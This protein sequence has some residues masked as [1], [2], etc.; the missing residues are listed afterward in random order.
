M[1]N[2]YVYGFTGQVR[3]SRIIGSARTTATFNTRGFL[4]L[5]SHGITK[6]N[7]EWNKKQRLYGFYGSA[8]NMVE[9]HS[10]VVSLELVKLLN[11]MSDCVHTAGDGNKTITMIPAYSDDADA[12]NEEYEVAV[13]L[14]STIGSIDELAKNVESVQYWEFNWEIL[15][16]IITLPTNLTLLSNDALT[17]D[18]DSILTGDDDE[19]LTEG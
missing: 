6:T 7:I 9:N 19:D 16:N 3:F 13:A 17:G 14:G 2:F 12:I 8:K 1:S 18:D 11:M 5:V 15:N 4:K 10:S